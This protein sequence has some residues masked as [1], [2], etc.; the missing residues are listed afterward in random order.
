MGAVV[1]DSTGSVMDDGVP[2]C[3]GREGTTFGAEHLGVDEV[4]RKAIHNTVIV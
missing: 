1:E 4:R 2:W 3:Y